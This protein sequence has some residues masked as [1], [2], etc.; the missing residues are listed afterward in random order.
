MAEDSHVEKG[1]IE[2]LANENFLAVYDVLLDIRNEMEITE[3]PRIPLWQS[4]IKFPVLAPM[5]SIWHR[6][7]YCEYRWKAVELLKR[8]KVIKEFKYL[9]GEHRWK[10]KIAIEANEIDVNGT[11]EIFNKLYEERIRNEDDEHKGQ[12]AEIQAGDQLP[13]EPPDKVT[14]QWLIKHVPVMLWLASFGLLVAAYSFGVKTSHISLI[15]DLY[16][17]ETKQSIKKSEA[18]DIKPTMPTQQTPKKSPAGG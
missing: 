7:R 9:Q 4:I 5:D 3:K 16:G 10:S 17:L 13:L 2:K 8:K 14:I 6:D 15:R 18:I 1:W 12:S 11:V